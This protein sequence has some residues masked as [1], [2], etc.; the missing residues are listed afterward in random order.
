MLACGGSCA[1]GQSHSY[2]DGVAG[3]TA[4]DSRLA[5]GV[6]A[7]DAPRRCLH[8]HAQPAGHL[9]QVRRGVATLGQR[10]VNLAVA[11]RLNRGDSRIIGHA[12]GDLV[13]CGT[14]SI[15]AT[16]RAG[17]LLGHVLGVPHIVVRFDS[18]GEL[19]LNEVV[20]GVCRVGAGL[21]L[22]A[23]GAV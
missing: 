22:A 7:V 18:N 5:V 20:H 12:H 14:V 10:R 13:R 15:G 21:E 3:A 23:A 1:R 2:G 4:P 9:V 19:G 17:A 16:R 11:V 8:L 6:N